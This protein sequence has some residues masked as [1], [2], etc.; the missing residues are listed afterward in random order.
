LQP[1][2]EFDGR[3]EEQGIWR[4]RRATFLASVRADFL[5]ILT[6]IAEQSGSVEVGE[7]F[8]RELRA[9]RINGCS[10]RKKTS[11]DCATFTKCS[12]NLTVRAAPRHGERS[13]AIQRLRDAQLRLCGSTARPASFVVGAGAGWLRFARHDG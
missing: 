12:K 10:R 2:P 6:Y 1:L 9:K 5:G 8:V 11:V 3:I 13:E 4:V 7:A